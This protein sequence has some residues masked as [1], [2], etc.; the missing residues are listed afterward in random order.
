[1]ETGLIRKTPQ[2]L[3]ACFC[4]DYWPQEGVK[5]CIH[6]CISIAYPQR[7]LPR[8]SLNNTWPPW[9]TM[10]ETLIHR[11][12][13]RKC[14]KCKI[15]NIFLPI[16]W[17]LSFGCSK[18]PSHWDGSFEYPQHMFWMRNKVNSFPIRTLIWKSVIPK[19][20]AKHNAIFTQVKIAYY[21][22]YFKGV[23]KNILFSINGVILY[24]P[25]MRRRYSYLIP[26]PANCNNTY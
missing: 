20:T 11:S 8:N 21:L 15:A 5:V 24:K 14:Y 22:D 17:N 26:W 10:N 3:L 13:K 25:S 16:H 1:M 2:Q 4:R 18:E 6:Y 9:H 7:R 12:R 19:T 23:K